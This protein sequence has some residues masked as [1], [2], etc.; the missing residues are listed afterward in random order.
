M[1]EET[2]D[3]ESERSSGVRN[4]V[5]ERARRIAVE[6]STRRKKNLRLGAIGL[7]SIGASIA[8]GYH[9]GGRVGTVNPNAAWHGKIAVVARAPGTAPDAKGGITLKTAKG[10]SAAA[11]G[12]EI[13]EGTEIQTDSRTRARIAFDDGTSI[14][15][16][17]GTRVLIESGPRTM[18][19]EDGQII[20]DVAHLEGA[21]PAK[22]ATPNGDVA[23][24]GTKLALT[25]EAD[26]TSV[27][28]LRGQVEL[29]DGSGK[30]QIGAGEEG[31]AARGAQLTVAPVN[32]LA[33]RLAFGE[34]L[35]LSGV[36][37]EDTDLPVSGLGELR[38]RRP[39]KTDEKDHALA[40][41]H[42]GAK[43]RIA[44]NVAR[45]EIDETFTNDTNDDLE[46]IYRFPLPPGA[47]IERLALEEKGQLIDGSFVDTQRGEAIFRGAIHNA[48]PD[49][50]KPK[51]EIIWV[52]GPWRDPALLE[53]QRGGRFELRIFPIPKHGSRRVVIAYTETVQPVAGLRR[54]TYP[55]PDAAALTIGSFDADVQVV[56]QDPKAGVK[57]RG[58]E[59]AKASSE[60][61]A[62][63]F[64]M[65]AQSFVPSGDLTVEYAM[66][67]RSTD[68]TAWG[69]ADS[70]TPSNATPI[71]AQAAV[72][73]GFGPGAAPP[74]NFV[75]LAFRPKMPGW[76]D[77]QPHDVVIAVDAGRSMFG[78]RF[79]RA[80]RLAVQIVQ[81][82]DRRDRVAVLACDTTCK[83]MQGGLVAAGSTSAHDADSFLAGIEP[84]GASDLVGAVRAA[85]SISGARDASRRL[86]VVMLSDG[87]ASAGY[88]TGDRI[89]QEVHDALS[90]AHDE[91]V[92]V[93]I[94]VDADTSTL[95]EIARGGGGVVVPYAPGEMLET[96]A[97]DVVNATYGVTLRDVELTLPSGLTDSAPAQIAPIRAGGEVIVAAR[98]AGSE[99]DGDAVLRGKVAG[100]PFEAR[101]PL[102]V[103]ASSDLGNAFV[104]RLYASARISDEERGQV[105]PQARADVV[106]LSQRFHVA[107]KFTSL[108]VLESEAMFRAFGIKRD[109]A[110]SPLWTG[111]NE[112]TSTD[113]AT[114]MPDEEKSADAKSLSKDDDA[115][116]SGADLSGTLDGWS[117]GAPGHGRAGVSG[118]G[119]GGGGASA[120]TKTPPRF[121]APPARPSMI[122]PKQ[123]SAGGDANDN[124]SRRESEGRK[125]EADSTVTTTPAT[126]TPPPAP[127]ATATAAAPQNAPL[128]RM[129]PYATNKGLRGIGGGAIEQLG[130]GFGAGQWM[131]RVWTRVAAISASSGAAVSDEKIAAARA[132]LA[133]APDE[134]ARYVDLVH[135]LSAAGATE[136][137]GE[138]LAK[139]SSRDP[140][141]DAATT[142]RADLAARAGDRD[143]ALRIIDGVAAG[144]NAPTSKISLLESLALAHERAGDKAGGCA[145][146][147]AVADVR[148]EAVGRKSF[149]GPDVERVARAV[150]CERSDA[151]ETSA[152]R[153]LQGR[154]ERDQIVGLAGR[155][156]GPAQGIQENT[157]FGDVVAEA[158]WDPAAN[159]DV[160][161]AIVDP[162]G[163]RLSWMGKSSN[164]RVAQPTSRR[165][166]TLAVTN[167]SSGPFTIEIVRG[168]GGTAPV[169][170][171]LN[172]RSLGQTMSVPFLLTGVRSSVAR[173]DMKLESHLV[174]VTNGSSAF[175]QSTAMSL[176]KNVPLA[177]CSVPNGPNGAGR[178][179]VLFDGSGR[180]SNVVVSTPFTGTSV[181]SCIVARLSRLHVSP[182]D[183]SAS[184]ARV[185]VIPP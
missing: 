121:H 14:A 109:D 82:M 115:F 123:D 157:G 35:G 147:L 126:P 92:A 51:E 178:A 171:T 45:T 152:E 83:A 78:E 100:E 85:S 170:G 111:E 155:F 49:Q 144:I 133:A 102:H 71:F 166:E 90:S 77:A 117:T 41:A 63:R 65:S 165:R 160:D 112:A 1:E 19:L 5:A 28:V 180:V 138:V 60:G 69:F 56:G 175:D 167:F 132:A 168:A 79:Q 108:L 80:R 73:A 20:A 127:A 96:A 40:I 164:V 64:T 156:D 43:I 114:L 105:S 34:R 110:T 118:T 136:E 26:R 151:R 107:S 61:K 74:K 17:R 68:V 13:G 130:G 184:V 162:S 24:L 81:E 140:L 104:P 163:N 113:V 59:L 7:L 142:A 120:E 95:S 125:K 36:H 182:F 38:A 161:I 179:T 158:T 18:K 119:A 48:T 22:I 149:V 98:M 47:Q 75:A 46:G 58:Y 106:D 88:R 62:D 137:L 145:F 172:V 67:D 89:E 39:G 146:R 55:L 12:S 174:P 27:E 42:H 84:D 10:T 134:R 70:S 93:P 143:R 183:G 139:W 32:D 141:D 50:P 31:I 131:K 44:G 33:Q 6:A 101:Y 21:N 124:A 23:V 72:K 29:H 148:A 116:G 169:N 173:V 37:N 150:A 57:I 135:L 177:Q 185:F 87:I 181:G 3:A 86:R 2:S 25:S 159:V 53:W 91:A 30:V 103:V 16:D 11:E 15:I 66:D 122:S 129:D 9:V 128:D 52:P 76:T 154:A 97:L 54:Y 99:V 153:W 4:G 8:I 176:V 94:G